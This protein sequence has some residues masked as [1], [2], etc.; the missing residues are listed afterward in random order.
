[1][2]PLPQL[3]A[4]RKIFGLPEEDYTVSGSPF[5]LLESSIEHGPSDRP[6]GQAWL[7]KAYLAAGRILAQS[8]QP[9]FG[10]LVH[11]ILFLYR[12]A[13]ELGLKSACEMAR[14]H[15]AIKHPNNNL[16]GE[17]KL[18]VTHSLHYLLDYLKA[19]IHD[20]FP[21]NAIRQVEAA[22]K[23]FHSID[24][25]SL[26]FRYLED[27]KGG[28]SIK[29]GARSIDLSEALSLTDQAVKWLEGLTTQFGE[30]I[31]C[32]IEMMSENEHYEEH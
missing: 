9:I 15:S 23:Y 25:K 22:V 19:L 21:K 4:L 17:G 7:G 6:H 26:A 13:L 18:K 28:P 3:E 16:V 14:F 32:Y 27:Q 29:G 31:D 20:D 5:H 2:R 8:H 11:P 24:P 10:G 12:H 1:M 30:N